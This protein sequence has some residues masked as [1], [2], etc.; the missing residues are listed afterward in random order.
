MFIFLVRVLRV[1]YT[2]AE[3]REGREFFQ[4]WLGGIRLEVYF[5]D[6]GM[7]LSFVLSKVQSGIE[8]RM[9]QRISINILTLR[10]LKRNKLGNKKLGN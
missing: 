1:L 9:Q 10:S 6:G 2:F 4:N 3:V 7:P 5:M 8:C